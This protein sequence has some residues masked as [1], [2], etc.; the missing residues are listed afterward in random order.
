MNSLVRFEPI[1]YL[2][3]GHITQDLSPQGPRLGGTASYAALTARAMGLR[4]GIV[5]ACPA[6]LN[7]PELDGIPIARLCCEQATTFNNIQTPTGRVQTLLYKAPE[8]TLTQ[9]PEIWQNAPV[10]HLGPVAQE[11]DPNLA[12]SF[13]NS[14][15]C[16]TPQG[17]MRAWDENGRVHYTDWMEA[18]YVLE[19]A[20]ACVISFDDVQCSETHIDEM[21]LAV[22][23]LVVT[24]G[25]SGCRLFWNGDLRCFKPPLEIEVDPT[26]AGDIF[27]AGFFARLYATRDPWEAARFATLIAARSVTRLSLEGVPTPQEVQS[28]L[29]EILSKS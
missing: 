16:V 29:L 8:L 26:G 9:V 12:R 25:A 15:V 18:A 14:L 5:T 11:V 22:R 21:L 7:L 20:A 24:E 27:A 4:V 23:L 2:V 3:I 19:H 13:P 28:S 17:W 10:V 6:D 1:D